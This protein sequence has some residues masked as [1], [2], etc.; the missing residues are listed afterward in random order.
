ML[1]AYARATATPDPSHV[2]DLHHSSRQHQ[3]LNPLSEA[4]DLT[5]N[6]MVPSWIRFLC[7]TMGTPYNLFF[8]GYSSVNFGKCTESCNY[9]MMTTISI[10][11]LTCPNPFFFKKIYWNTVNLKMVL[12]SGLQQS[13]SVLHIHI[14][15]HFQI[16]FLFKLPH[17]TE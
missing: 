16:L 12:I 17:S 5:C 9:S 10:H 8:W 2:C 7:P 1:P 3:I 6:L 4:R 13:K 11:S 14:S 15:I